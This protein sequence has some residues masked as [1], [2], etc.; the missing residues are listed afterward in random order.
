[1]VSP[2]HSPTIIAVTTSARRIN[3]CII[4]WS[5]SKH[6]L[7]QQEEETQT[8]MNTYFDSSDILKFTFSSYQDSV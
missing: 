1:M 3:H 6:R 8:Y 2:H 7:T 5:K 4:D